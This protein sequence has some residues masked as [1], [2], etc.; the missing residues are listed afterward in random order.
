MD[1]AL[2]ILLHPK[3]RPDMY[4][5]WIWGLREVGLQDSEIAAVLDVDQ[6]V[7]K[8]WHMGVYTPSRE[9][10][11]VLKSLSALVRDLLVKGCTKEDV[12]YWLL[13]PE[14]FRLDEKQPIDLVRKSPHRVQAAACEHALAQMTIS[15]E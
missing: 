9:Q 11:T 6:G 15:P 4:Q 8:E 13:A 10:K 7:I 12:V 1:Q 2:P 14:H 3:P 5:R